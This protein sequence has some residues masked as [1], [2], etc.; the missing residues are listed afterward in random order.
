MAD[1]ITAEVTRTSMLG[2]LLAWCNDFVDKS[3]TWRRQ[4]WEDK[5]LNYQRDADAIYDPIIADSKQKWQSKAFIPLI[6]SHRESLKAQLFKTMVGGR[7]V[8]EVKTRTNVRNDQSLNI[9]DLILREIEKSRFE[10]KFDAVVDDA[11]TYG[12]GFC[13]IRHETTTADRK[14]RVPVQGEIDPAIAQALAARG[15]L[16]PQ[17]PVVGYYS[18]IREVV[19]YRGVKF[20]WINIWDLYPDPRALEICGN[21]FALAY[22]VTYGE[23]IAG[24][25]KGYFFVEAIEKLRNIDDQPT[26]KKNTGKR[27]VRDNRRQAEV[28]VKTPDYG[29]PLECYELFAR[30]PKKWVYLAGEEIADPETLVPSRII[31]HQQSVLAVELNDQYDGNA[32]IFKMDYW[33]VNGQFYGRGIPEMLG[34]LQDVVNEGVNQRI[35]TLTITLNKTWALLEQFIVNSEEIG[36][37]AGTVVRVDA[38]A[39]RKAGFDDIRKVIMELPLGNIDRAAYVDAQEMERYAQERTSANKVTLGTAQG[40]DVNDTARGMELLRSITNEKLAYIGMIAEFVFLH[41]VFREY[42]KVIYA[43]LTPVD[44]VN[45]LGDERAATF[46]LLSPE[47]IEQDYRYE[48]QGIFTQ[49]NRAQVQ[50][51]LAAVHEQFRD[52]P[53]VK[54]EAFFDKELQSINEDPS[55]YRLTPEELQSMLVAQATMRGPGPAQV[56]QR[57]QA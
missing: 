23:V 30:L 9:R 38:A 34:A 1:S 13:R 41:D 10:A 39:M 8:I 50:I 42:W 47:Q 49:E 48:P 51:R 37:N 15:Q 32:P 17:P 2:E 4:S 5:W 3:R 56:E 31:F 33:Q 18:E 20:S 36:K 44:V 12:S 57:A 54:H 28:K 40:K 6:P 55:S 53:W 27:T 16:P 14:M 7:P 26:D 45:A 29:R 22:N 35:D 11:S 43:N 52:Q 21:S 19:T 24:A 25:A 46:E